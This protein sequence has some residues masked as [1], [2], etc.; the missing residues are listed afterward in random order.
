MLFLRTLGGLALERDGEPVV[1]VATQRVRLSLLAVLAL[2]R[3]TG[4]SRDKLLPLFWPESDEL[5]ARGALKQ[6]LFGVRRGLSQPDLIEGTTE[7]RLNAS[8]ITTDVWEFERAIDNQDFER[9]VSTYTGGFLDGVFVRGSTAFEEWADRERQRLAKAYYVALEQLGRAAEAGGRLDKALGVWRTLAGAQPLSGR[10]ALFYMNGLAASGDREAAIHHASAYAEAVRRELDAEP[11]PEVV[12]LANQLR[13]TGGV[14]RKSDPPRARVATAAPLEAGPSVA[15]TRPATWQRQRLTLIGAAAAIIT[16]LALVALTARRAYDPNTVVV[17]PFENETADTTFDPL[18]RITSDWVTRGLERTQLLDVLDS[19]TLTDYVRDS[20]GR[21]RPSL[22]IAQHAG[23]GTLVRGTIYRR[24]DSLLVVARI[25]RVS[26]GSVLADLDPVRAP[27]DDPQR[28]LE[29]LRQQIMGAFA[30]L[31]DSRIKQWARTPSTPPTYASYL[32][33]SEGLDAITKRHPDSAAVHFIRAASLDST[34]TLAPVLLF[35]ISDLP[36]VRRV[37]HAV[38]FIDSLERIAPSQRDR[39]TPNDQAALDAEIARRHAD[40]AR[41]LDATRRM[42]A[43]A[44]KSSNARFTHAHTLIAN[45]YFGDAIEQLHQIDLD[46]SW[47]KDLEYFWVW[48]ITAHH[49]NDDFTGALREAVRAQRRFPTNDA[50][51]FMA[52]D[53]Q[54]A[55]GREQDVEAKIAN[56]FRTAGTRVDSGG[57]FLTVGYE[58]QAHRHEAEAQRF[59]ARALAVRLAKNPRAPAPFVRAALGRWQEAYEATKGGDTTQLRSIGERA[60]FAARSGDR[61]A[62][63]QLAK[64]I[65]ER[66][67]AA[68]DGRGEIWLA[69]VTLALGHRDSAVALLRRSV[70]LGVAPAFNL[71]AQW[72]LHDLDTYPPFRQIVGPKTAPSIP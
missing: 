43:I 13:S 58:F 38:A 53:Q 67:R 56:C 26:D 17:A 1:G 34:F 20:T 3:R 61:D 51:C 70:D 72:Y 10:A 54:A 4:V 50:F 8:A 65:E 46:H 66:A 28:I 59:F 60:V 14:A 12:Q 42:V 45:N 7:L 47:L 48:E 21:A 22:A 23:A 32:E 63:S 68:H 35:G 37:P 49:Q 25:L 62:A 18:S 11:D 71:H 6:A 2:S 30:L 5:R 40:W 36:L 33:Y 44:P 16:T 27:L 55:M 52:A 69:A 31:S 41:R 15:S 64:S 29:P 24:G 9:A 19:R 57:V 39:M